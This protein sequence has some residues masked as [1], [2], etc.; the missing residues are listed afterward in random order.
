MSREIVKGL[1]AAGKEVELAIVP[2]SHKVTQDAQLVYN[3]KVASLV[4]QGAKGGERLL[5]R[6]EVER[7]M[8]EMG[9]WTVEDRNRFRRL[10]NDIHVLEVVLRKGGMKLSEGRSIALRMMD[11]RAELLA[12]YAKRAQLDSATIEAVAENHRFNYLV[13]QC[14]LRA[15]TGATFFADLDDYLDRASEPVAVQVAM[16]L[17]KM[18]YGYND[19]FAESAYE[20]Q[21]LKKFK[22]AD[23][24]G[25]LTD[26]QGRLVDREGRLVNEMGRYVDE[27]GNLIDREGNR[28]DEN[29]DLLIESAPFTE[30]DGTPIETVAPAPAEPPKKGKRARK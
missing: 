4:R 21:W 13:S 22:L 20:S 2:P 29:G 14:A 3:L 8:E 7:H 25:R 19:K 18:L 16:T 26:R 23:D 15:D 27:Q 24:Q 12:L 11:F 9:I 10:Q 17:A 6:S 28:V 5:L 1:D 30:D